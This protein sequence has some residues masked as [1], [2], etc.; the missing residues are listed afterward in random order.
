[1]ELSLNKTVFYLNRIKNFMRFQEYEAARQECEAA[2]LYL[3]Q[4][5]AWSKLTEGSSSELKP[6]QIEIFPNEKEILK[7]EGLPEA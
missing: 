4:V 7:K 2:L 6:G 3:R 5:E 1:M